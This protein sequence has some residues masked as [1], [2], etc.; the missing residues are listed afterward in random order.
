MST[1]PFGAAGFGFPAFDPAAFERMSRQWFSA[2]G[3]APAPA[4]SDP[5]GWWKP[6][7]PR[8]SSFDPTAL[9]GQW[10][11]QMQQLAAQ[12]GGGVETNAADIARAWRSML[13]D[14]PFAQAGFANAFM[15]AAFFGAGAN[16]APR[17]PFDLPAFGYTR[18]H[19]ERM[20]SFAKATAEFQQASQAFNAII[21]E[22]GQDAF[23]RF[24][25]LLAKRGSD[26]KPVD[27]ARGLFDL[28]IDAAEDAYADIALGDR[29][30]S[31]FGDYVNAQM[32]VRA[33]M[34]KEVEVACAQWGIPGRAEVDAAHRKVAQ[35]ERELRRLREAFEAMGT[36]RA[37][38]TPKP[39]QA[40]SPKP[41]AAK[42]APPKTGKR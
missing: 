22:A 32:R 13:G 25:S 41:R 14:N 28:W 39:D 36:P 16:G 21:A 33:A 37:P 30:Q 12:F 8:A 17:G 34:Q 26:G 10:M 27:S 3:A 40:E 7:V 42:A 31:A 11:T 19:Q 24:E 1:S 5:F 20:Q 4:P 35:L 18:E 29:F 23:A 9:A 6:A 2:M 38:E 15:P